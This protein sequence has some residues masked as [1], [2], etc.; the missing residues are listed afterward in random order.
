MHATDDRDSSWLAST[1]M[2]TVSG[3]TDSQ[4][5]G[6][7]VVVLL[8]QSLCRLSSTQ[9][10][11]V[12][13]LMWTL[14]AAGFCSSTCSRQVGP[15]VCA[16]LA[17]AGIR[18]H[19]HLYGFSAGTHAGLCQHASCCSNTTAAPAQR[20]CTLKRAEQSS[21][22][23]EPWQLPSC[24]P[25]AKPATFVQ[26]SISSP[27]PGHRFALHTAGRPAACCQRATIQWTHHYKPC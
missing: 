16:G 19:M 10:E 9:H 17:R 12:C 5:A 1:K 6:M 11:H 7:C 14:P 23:E 24:L 13:W 26:C 15:L 25:K 20:Q 27:Q 8:W 18:V 2:L 3:R 4:A 21:A 22:L